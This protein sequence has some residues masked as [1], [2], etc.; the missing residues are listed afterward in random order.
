MGLA[1]VLDYG[2]WHHR[3]IDRCSWLWYLYISLTFGIKA[4]ESFLRCGILY[5]SMVFD[6]V[7]RCRNHIGCGICASV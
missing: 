6:I 5:F 4:V 3:Q 2:F 1:F 7:G